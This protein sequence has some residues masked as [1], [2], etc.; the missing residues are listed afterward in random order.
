MIKAS[1]RCFIIGQFY[2]GLE[3]KAYLDSNKI[4]TI[5]I[6]TTIYPNGKEVKMGETCTIDQA[7]EWY[8]WGMREAEEKLNR[9][10]S[11]WNK[12]TLDQHRVDALLD[13]VYNVGYGE[14]LIKKINKNPDDP[15][16]WGWFIM[17]DKVGAEKDGKD[18]DHDGKIDELGEMKEE[19]GLLR[20]RNCEAH[21]WFKNEIHF[22][23]EL[24]TV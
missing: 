2:E 4:P 11:E 9:W 10:L 7:K 18:N 22:Y 8:V 5:G 13:F 12:K 23:Q 24:K 14:G 17:Y 3:L 20:R 15:S 1:E 21:L 16:I 19:L 6:G